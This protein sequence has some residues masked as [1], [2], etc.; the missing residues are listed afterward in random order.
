M[1]NLFF[2]LPLKTVLQDSILA[3]FKR[4]VCFLHGMNENQALDIVYNC[5]SYYSAQRDNLFYS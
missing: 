2:S 5:R 4:H 3:V 1:V